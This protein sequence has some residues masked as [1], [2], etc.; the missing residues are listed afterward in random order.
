M[1][2]KKT[3]D[4]RNFRSPLHDVP[5]NH[6]VALARYTPDIIFMTLSFMLL[7]LSFPTSFF[8]HASF[9]LTSFY[10]VLSPLFL[11]LTLTSLSLT[12]SYLSHPSLRYTV[13][14]YSMLYPITT[15]LPSS[16]SQHQSSLSSRLFPTPFL[17]HILARICYSS[18]CLVHTRFPW[19]CLSE[20]ADRQKEKLNGSAFRTSLVS[21]VSAEKYRRASA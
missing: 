14:G 21:K 19:S 5:Y 17:N 20:L 9:F 6:I 1:H 12:L 3:P 11:F 8:I 10:T 7:S 13:N 2:V 4:G 15:I 16:L 18:S